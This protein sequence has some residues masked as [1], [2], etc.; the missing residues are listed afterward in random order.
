MT[1]QAQ[2]HKILMAVTNDLVSD[3][4]VHK[5]ALTLCNMGFDVTLAG[6]KLKN[7]ES[8]SN[9]PYTTK[10]FR[11]CF[12]KG[13]LFYATYNIRLLIYLIFNK[14]DVINANDL[15]TLW[16]CFA[17]SKLTKTQL[18]YDSHEY[19]T[20]VP[21]LVHRPGVKKIWEKIEA[22]IVPKLNTCYTVCQSI[23]TIYNQKYGCNFRVVRNVP[24][25]SQNT[26]TDKGFTPPFETDLPII[27]YQ[28]AINKDRG[29][30]ESILAMH[31]VN[32]AQ[33][34]IIGDGDVF[35]KC[36]ELTKTENLTNKVHFTGR[37]NLHQL[38]KITPFATI[39]LS[40]EKDVGLNYH[41]ALPNKLFDYIHASIPVIAASLPEIKNIVDTYKIG[42]C[43][44][45]ITPVEISQAIN[46]LI[47]NKQLINQLRNNC[48]QAQNEL[49]WENEE[50][51]IEN[52]Y[53]I[54]I[55]Q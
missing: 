3:N 24:H 9:R 23:A 29:I 18:V 19:Y 4:R 37:I 42:V 14:F 47:E 31:T 48:I 51:I 25:K 2:K 54:F 10:R 1:Q 33:L 55:K 50:K 17:A 30:E 11:L 36:V 21:D 5:I 34:V 28:G 43:I 53:G 35:K 13:P 22:H 45:N 41:Y 7:S 40:V 15:D 39:G 16:A 12:N 8:V 49:C 26:N 38:S 20:E 52:I 27:L 46:K 6:R 32:N 44:N